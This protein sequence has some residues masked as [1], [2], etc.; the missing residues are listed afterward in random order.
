MADDAAWKISV[1]SALRAHFKQPAGPSKPGAEWLVI[2][3]CPGN[4][5]SVMVRAY[6][7]DVVGYSTV[8]EAKA[9]ATY[10]GELLRTG[11][12]PASYR[13]LPGELTLPKQPPIDPFAQPPPQ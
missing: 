6:D 4:E 9:V 3:S 13:Q 5:T 11:W 2:L 1:T 8:Q 7:E 12:S 10:V